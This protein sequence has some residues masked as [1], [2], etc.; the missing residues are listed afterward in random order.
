MGARGRK[1]GADGEKSRKLMLQI[2]AEEFAKNGFH[3]TKIS[4]IVK[5]AGVTQ[6]AFYLY[7]PSKEAI[8][9]ELIDQFIYKLEELIGDSR[10]ESDLTFDSLPERIE[11]GLGAIFTF[12]KQNEYLTKIAFINSDYACKIK[13]QLAT[14]IEENLLVEQSYGYFRSD[15]DIRI[16]AEIV[17]STMERLTVTHLWTNQKTDE[18]ITE[19][20]VQII[21]NGLIKRE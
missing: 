12:F 6:P 2:A 1:K 5:R 15:L 3:H 20:T 9:Q 16:A 13:E 19:E 21:L 10:L 17:V 7:F 11:E 8:F 18:E 4:T 14:Q